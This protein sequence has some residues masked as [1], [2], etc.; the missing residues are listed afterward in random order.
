MSTS[1]TTEDSMDYEAA[2]AEAKSKQILK[3]HLEIDLANGT[4]TFSSALTSYT[5]I[6]GEWRDAPQGSNKT[7]N[8]ELETRHHG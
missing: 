1:D 6:E 5:P 4:A 2:K 3:G 7:S 8:S